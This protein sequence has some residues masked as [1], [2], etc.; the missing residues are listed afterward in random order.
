MMHLHFKT[1]NLEL[2][3]FPSQSAAGPGH[4]D[5]PPNTLGIRYI[6][7]ELVRFVY[8]VQRTMPRGAT[9]LRRE[10]QTKAHASTILFLP[11][12]LV[13]FS[14][15]GLLIAAEFNHSTPL[16]LPL[17]ISCI[18]LDCIDGFLARLLGQQTSFGAFLDV[19]VDI[20]LRGCLWTRAIPGGGLMSLLFPLIEF[21]TF[22][23]TH[24]TSRA[25]DW[26]E[27]CFREA[28]SFIQA[29]MANGLRNPWGL[30]ASLGLF[31]LPLWLFIQQVDPPGVPTIALSPYLGCSLIVGRLLALMVE[32]WLILRYLSGVL[33]QDVRDLQARRQA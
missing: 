2:R 19:W 28:P 12:N 11:P 31:F 8:L 16:A 10:H 25:S 33:E 18:L 4:H 7:C 17:Y 13:T 21:T 20:A 24:S 3:E 22:L 27:G 14:R 26:K 15:L 5:G 23:I 6:E 1:C 29:V 30:W 32:G 9:A